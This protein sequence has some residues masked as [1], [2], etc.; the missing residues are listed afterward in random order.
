MESGRVGFATD[1]RAGTSCRVTEKSSSA[2]PLTRF[3]IGRT[4]RIIGK[5][6]TKSRAG[7]HR[8]ASNPCS[9]SKRTVTKSETSGPRWIPTRRARDPFYIHVLR[10]VWS[11]TIDLA[12]VHKG[13]RSPRDAEDGCES[14]EARVVTM[15]VARWNMQLSGDRCLT[16]TRK[17]K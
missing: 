7:R 3:P 11:K 5:N 8:A 13:S 9:R 10:Y 15:R 4:R 1:R 16:F 12:R 6:R 17:K 2:V 14:A